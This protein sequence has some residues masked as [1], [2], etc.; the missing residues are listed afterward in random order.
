MLFK[1]LDHLEKTFDG[2]IKANNLKVAELKGGP[3]W[4]PL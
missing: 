1:I 2:H 4:L 3:S